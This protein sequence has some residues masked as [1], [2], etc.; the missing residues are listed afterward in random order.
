MRTRGATSKPTACRLVNDPLCFLSPSCLCLGVVVRSQKQPKHA[1]LTGWRL[2]GGYFF[3]NA[4][5]PNLS[6]VDGPRYHDEQ[7][8]CYDRDINSQH[9][10]SL[11]LNDAMW[12]CT[13]V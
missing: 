11:F 3:F 1:H 5:M 8:P 2:V 10:P 6:G 13:S 12:L 4:A 9:M 7:G